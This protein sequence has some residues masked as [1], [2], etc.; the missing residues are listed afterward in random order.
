MN[1]YTIVTND[2]YEFPVKIDVRFGEVVEFLGMSKTNVKNMI[3]KPRKKAKYKI[4]ITGKI[5]FDQNA[6]SKKYLLTH[7]RSEYFRKYYRERVETVKSALEEIQQYR[8]LGTV[9][10]LREAME[11]QRPMEHHHTRVRRVNRKLRESVCPNCLLVICTDEQSY[12][13]FCNWCGQ[14]IDWS[15]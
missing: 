9:E 14:A 7:D 13:K 6:Y 15:R 11:K 1:L 12:P 4:L 2:K 5:K 8:E 3:Y 10:E